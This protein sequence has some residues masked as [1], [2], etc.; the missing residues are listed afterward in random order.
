MGWM[1]SRQ[2]GAGADKGPRRPRSPMSRRR[3]LI[4]ALGVA[5]PLLFILLVILADAWTSLL[6]YQELGYQ[7]VFWTRALMS[8]AVGAAA[9]ALFFAVFFGNVYLARRLSPRLRVAS[10]GDPDV[11]ELVQRRRF[12]V[13]LLILSLVIAFFVGL[14]TGGSWETVLLFARRVAFGFQDPI[15]HR[16]A[17]FFVYLLPFVTTLLSLLTTILI[18]TL[19]GTVFIYLLDRAVTLIDGRR[20]VFAPH[21]KAH[22]SS[23]IAAALL[24]KAVDYLVQAWDLVLSPSG[25]IFGARYTDVHAHLPVLRILAVV[26]AISAVILLINIHYKGWR[27]PIV[28]VGLIVAF[29]VVAGQIYP[30]LVQQYRVSPNEVEAETPYIADNIAATRWAYSLDRITAKAF[31][32]DGRLTAANI[33]ANPLTIDNIRLWDPGTLLDA[34]EPLQELRLYYSFRDVDVDRYTIQGRYRQ[35]MLAA[36]ELD[37]TKLQAQSQTWVNQHLTYT[38]GYGAV[39]SQ[40][41][42]ATSEGLPD[43]WLSDIPPHSPVG[44]KITRPQIYYGELGNQF[45][46]VKT[47]AKEYD[48]PKGQDNAYTTYAG[49]G[50]IGLGSFAR[51]AAFAL[52]FGTL[53]LLLTDYLSPD[54]RI[55]YRRDVGERVKTI[56][57]FLHY[58]RDPYLVIRD[59]GSLVW[60]WDAYTT[61]DRFPYSQPREGGV[62]YVRNSVKVVVDAY[63]GGVTFYQIDPKDAVATTWGKV[64]PGLFVPDDQL[65][66]DLRRHLRYPEDLFSVQASVITTYHMTDPQVFYGKEDVWEVPSQTNQTE[67]VPVAPY[68]VIMALPGEPAEEFLLMQ[69]YNALKKTNMVSWMAARMDGAHYGELVIFGFPKDKLVPGPPQV[70]NSISNDPAISAA[71]TL[72]SQA[73]SKVIRGNLLAIPIDDA[74][75]FVEPLY[76]QATENPIPELKRVILSYKD[77]VVMEPTLSGA[78]EKLFPPGG[79]PGTTVSGGTTTTTPPAG[80]T[81]TTTVPS[82]GTT[83][84]VTSPTTTVPSG[85]T[86]TTVPGAPLPTDPAALAALAQQHYEA[87]LQAQKQGDWAEYGRQIDE[88]GR[89]LAALGAVSK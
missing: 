72:W 61:A 36:R 78:L 40:V 82:T 75:L 39:A 9:G 59:D 60:I 34:Y 44:L 53:K 32:A 19:I 24:L 85:T 66:A 4:I 11:L 46:V 86:T 16:D 62:N 2:E 64:F 38:H 74:L 25:L 30:A 6:W 43:F 81:T 5:V 20:L 26:A 42:G 35:V 14:G 65:P 88:L 68:Y 13:L 87:A 47:S 37:Q 45:I 21:V 12:P 10:T 29:W 80:G 73:G 22:L 48:Y 33:A 41:N 56:A 55:M 54:S 17:T 18:L 83:T 27:L 71:L 31:P 79:G 84:T 15:F 67:T 49:T 23:L 51:Q 28:A 57:P 70:E 50:G 1:A 7:Q 58:D 89:V 77:Q 8:L 63:N 52:R 69:P 3:R 76:L